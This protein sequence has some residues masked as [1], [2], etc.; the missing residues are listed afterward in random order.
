MVVNLS[1]LSLGAGAVI[2][3]SCC[4]KWILVLNHNTDH[5]FYSFLGLGYL[6]LG[7][8]FTPLYFRQVL[9]KIQHCKR[10][11]LHIV[12]ESFFS[13]REYNYVYNCKFVPHAISQHQ[14]LS[15]N[16]IRQIHQSRNWQK[17][18]VFLGK[19]DKV[20]QVK[21]QNPGFLRGE[22]DYWYSKPKLLLISLWFCVSASSRSLAVHESPRWRSQA[23]A[24]TQSLQLDSEGHPE[25]PPTLTSTPLKQERYV[26]L[27]K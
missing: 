12:S 5:K 24:E 23:D 10:L 19:T 22:H 8:V 7:D 13:V 2:F 21:L 18:V 26:C 14:S 16:F 4:S 9:A 27:K 3:L 1:C 20:P 6:C 15:Y 25:A 17:C 11:Q